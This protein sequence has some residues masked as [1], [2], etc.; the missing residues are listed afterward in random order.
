VY[1]VISSRRQ[2]GS[3]CFVGDGGIACRSAINREGK[4][5][6]VHDMGRLSA[7]QASV[8]STRSRRLVSLAVGVAVA[9]TALEAHEPAARADV[10]RTSEGRAVLLHTPYD[11][12]VAAQ[13]RGYHDDGTLDGGEVVDVLLS[14]GV[15]E[16]DPGGSNLSHQWDQVPDIVRKSLADTQAPEP[17]R[18][19][20]ASPRRS[21]PQPRWGWPLKA[22][23]ISSEFGRRGSRPHEGMD[24][25]ARVGE[26]I[27]AASPGTVIYAGSRMSG[28]GNALILHHGDDTTS[29]YAHATQL[30]VRKGDRVEPDTPIATVGR[31]GRATGAHLH[32]DIRPG[33]KPID[34]RDL[35][36]PTPI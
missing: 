30:R 21:S 3:K 22:G 12:K 32:I 27:Y 33:A 10:Q 14:A 18:G 6:G 2:R 9:W 1:A 15:L 31:T 35:Q 34:P 24:I 13:F 36:T 20:E 7:L 4:G 11:E 26:P 23:V 19:E 25:A 8:N 5:K 16:H 17:S 28:Y 29:L